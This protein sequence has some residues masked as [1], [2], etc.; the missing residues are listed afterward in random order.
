MES[1]NILRC[2]NAM[3]F[4]AVP[5][6]EAAP[7]LLTYSP[8]HLPSY[9]RSPIGPQSEKDRAQE[10]APAT[11]KGGRRRPHP[12]PMGSADRRSAASAPGKARCQR[13][14]SPLRGIRSPAPKPNV[15]A[16]Q[17]CEVESKRERGRV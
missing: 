16:S 15:P 17:R 6:A 14:G 8:P 13:G 3:T 4:F 5:P 12:R 1:V 9:L 2:R 11:V 7:A 10:S